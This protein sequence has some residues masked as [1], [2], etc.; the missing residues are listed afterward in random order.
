V[1][2]IDSLFLLSM[3]DIRDENEKVSNNRLIDNFNSK[4][5]AFTILLD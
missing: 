5:K 4:Y 1:E 2:N 3:H